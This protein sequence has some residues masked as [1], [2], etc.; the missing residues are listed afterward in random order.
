MVHLLSLSRAARLVGVTRGAL[1]KKIQN[2]EMPSFD[3]T[4]KVDDLLSVYPDAQLENNVEFDR[5]RLIKEKSFGKRVFERALPDAEVLAARVTELSTELA[6][7]QT[8]VRQFNILLDRLKIR[9]G[10]IEGQSKDALANA[11]H[12]FK[13]WLN[14]EAAA[15][16]QPGYA[17]PLAVRDSILRVMAAHVRVLPSG[18]D[19]FI[20]GPD[21]I[22]EA[23]LRAGIPLNYGC[24]GGNCGLCKAKVVSGQ[25]KKIRNHDYVIPEAQ[26]QQGYV[27]LCS[28]TAVTDVEIEAPVAGSVQDIPFQQLS[29]KVKTVEP[30]SQNMALL[31][32]QMPRTSRL[33]FLAGQYATVQVGKS[34]SA[35]LPIASCPCDERN[36]HFHVRRMPGNLFS[37]YIFN[38]LES[39]E[40][41]DVEGP[42]GEFILQ[43]KSPRPLY[44]IAFDAGFAPIKSLIEHAMSLDA[45]EAIHL[46]WIGSDG[47]GIYMPNMGRA[48]ADAL[49]NFFFSS[50]ITGYDLRAVS[51]KREANLRAM[52]E[53]ILEGCPDLQSGD[54]YI[55]GPGSAVEVAE[56]FFL[57]LGLPKSR[58]FTGLVK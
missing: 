29:A 14:N 28:S 31:H 15:A 24:S 39:N 17:N 2:G 11:L 18:H 36:L 30:L 43:E 19:F 5:V 41:V 20:D 8:Q 22:L 23:A 47:E 46:Y 56:D 42:Q 9:L 3:G 27:L 12:D 37:D 50:R 52:L 44:F 34:L 7:S 54:I 40:A 4:V 26:K 10:E 1:Q 45:A 16:M 6:N 51:G 35:D 21:S 33:R 53:E 25:I 38:H 32:L 58:V 55:A 48:W 49:D 13:T 57:N